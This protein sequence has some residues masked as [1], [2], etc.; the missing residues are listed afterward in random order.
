MPLA[1]LLFMKYKRRLRQGAY[2]LIVLF[3]LANVMAGFHAYKFTHYSMSK[4]PRTGDESSLSFTE[5]L[6]ALF[7][8]VSLPRAENKRQP[9]K[10]F[11]TITLQSN[12]RISCWLIKAERP[13]GTVALFHGYG[14]SKAT[15]LDKASV[16]QQLHYNTLLVD[17]MGAGGSEGNQT[18]VGYKEA[19]EVKTCVDY[20]RSHNERNIILF[21]T[22]MGAAAIMKAAH[23]DT[24]AVHSIILECPFGTML[25]TVENRFK[26]IGVPAFPLAHLLVFWGGAENGFNAFN[27]NP[28]TYARSIKCPV[29]LMWGGKDDKVSPEETAAIFQ[30]LAG[31]KRLL[32]F[33]EAGH[34][35]YLIKY[36]SGWIAGVASF[37]K[38]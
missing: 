37:L 28:E 20:L 6:N 26:T 5:K 22:S 4:R 15:L 33:P 36:K 38:Q 14:S 25:Q 34:E 35:N 9:A 17:F 11:E 21:G 3:V 31:P 30:N 8:G 32:T 2:T 12:S 16:F 29:L 7:L 10:L 13:L 27:H 19:A 1:D 18:T 23:D 24:M